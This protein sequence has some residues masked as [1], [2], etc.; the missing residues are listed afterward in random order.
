M[1]ILPQE[2]DWNKIKVELFFDDGMIVLEMHELE[3]SGQG[4]IEDP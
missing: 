4:M 2:K 3:F 1:G